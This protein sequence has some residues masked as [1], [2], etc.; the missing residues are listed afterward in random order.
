[1]HNTVEEVM[2]PKPQTVTDYATLVEAAQIMRDADVG[3]VVVL[4][5]G[6]PIGI[7]TDRDIVVRAVA[8]GTDPK[9][10]IMRDFASAKLETI[11]PSA[12]LGEAVRMMRDKAIRRLVVVEDGKPVGVVSLGDL[13]KELDEDS[14]LADISAAPPN[15]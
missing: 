7:I 14:A 4:G 13:A 15:D 9:T 10:A 3:D 8:E 12:P 6:V 11:A 2:T 5:N 1:M